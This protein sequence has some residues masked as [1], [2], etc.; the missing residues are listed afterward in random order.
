[1]AEHTLNKNNCLDG[2]ITATKFELDE[3]KDTCWGWMTSTAC[4]FVKTP[5]FL[6]TQMSPELLECYLKSNNLNISEDDLLLAVYNWKKYMHYP[7]DEI[8]TLM[9]LIR[10]DLLSVDVLVSNTFLLEMKSTESR[11]SALK[12]QAVNDE[13]K[14]SLIRPHLRN[15][16]RSMPRTVKLSPVTKRYSLFTTQINQY[17]TLSVRLKLYGPG[18]V[19]LGMLRHKRYPLITNLSATGSRQRGSK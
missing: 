1:M 17:F 15:H 3:L 19:S 13:D 7:D 18:Q 6:T 14:L 9:S 4:E 8:K 12:T 2:F 5:S 10:L 11:L 16:L